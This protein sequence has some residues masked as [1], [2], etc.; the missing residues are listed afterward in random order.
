MTD[1]DI[2]IRVYV[3]VRFRMRVY[4]RG[5]HLCMSVITFS[6]R[7]LY[8]IF[9][10]NIYMIRCTC[11][12]CDSLLLHVDNAS[13]HFVMVSSVIQFQW[14]VFIRVIIAPT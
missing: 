9:C 7:P 5:C 6:C 3:I 1:V 4:V 8:I 10:V 14:E 2:S 13:E 11:I 12:L